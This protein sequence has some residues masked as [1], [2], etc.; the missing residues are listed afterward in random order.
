MF[1]GALVSLLWLFLTCTAGAG[2]HSVN[3]SPQI[4][5][6]PAIPSD[7]LITLERSCARCR[8]IGPEYRLKISADGVVVYVGKGFVRKKGKARSRITQEQLRQLI[9]EFDKTNYFSLRDK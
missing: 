9:S 3:N 8:G 2:N 6:T 4:A 7:T 5:A 1:Q